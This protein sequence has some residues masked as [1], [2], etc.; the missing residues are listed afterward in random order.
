MYI[1]DT[2]AIIFSGTGSYSK[3]SS[4][5]KRV[6]GKTKKMTKQKPILWK[7]EQCAKTARGYL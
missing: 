3:T 5:L 7:D 6:E 1:L 4:Q 2:A